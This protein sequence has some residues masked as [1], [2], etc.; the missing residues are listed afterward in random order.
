MLYVPIGHT[1][2]TFPVY[3]SPSPLKFASTLSFFENIRGAEWLRALGLLEERTG[4]F[5]LDFLVA[6]DFLAGLRAR[7]RERQRL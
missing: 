6:R 2:V 4:F 1:F 5:W 7:E 3:H